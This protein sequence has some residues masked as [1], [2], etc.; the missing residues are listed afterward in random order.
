MNVQLEA[1]GNSTGIL[2]ALEDLCS[3]PFNKELIRL[4]YLVKI[5]K[6]MNSFSWL[7]EEY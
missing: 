3:T 5:E 6:C 7:L 2:E 4:N 1:D